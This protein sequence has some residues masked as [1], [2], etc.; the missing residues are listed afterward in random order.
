MTLFTVEFV[1]AGIAREFVREGDGTGGE[2]EDE[3]GED[4]ECVAFQDDVHGDA[5]NE[6]QQ[7]GEQDG[8]EFIDDGGFGIE[9]PVEIRDAAAGEGVDFCAADEQEEGEYGERVLHECGK[10]MEC[11]NAKGNDER[12]EDPESECVRHLFAE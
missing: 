3:G 8:A 12:V 9:E 4:D 6:E 11:E 5:G 10:C 2:R 1:L 7:V